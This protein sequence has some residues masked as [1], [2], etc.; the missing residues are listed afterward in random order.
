MHA[1]PQR[2]VQLIVRD[3]VGLI[4]DE[5]QQQIECFRREMDLA[6]VPSHDARAFV[7]DNRGH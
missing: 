6:P 7:D 4:P 5:D 3:G 1:G 2:G